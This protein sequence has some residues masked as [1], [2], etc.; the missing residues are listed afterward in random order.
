MRLKA[1]YQPSLFRY[2]NLELALFYAH[3]LSTTFCPSSWMKINLDFES[4]IICAIT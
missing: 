3:S 1:C 4:A 2:T